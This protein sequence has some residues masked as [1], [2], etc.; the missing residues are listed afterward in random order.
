MQKNIERTDR[1][2]SDQKIDQVQLKMT[3]SVDLKRHAGG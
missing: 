2:Y 3:M 1:N